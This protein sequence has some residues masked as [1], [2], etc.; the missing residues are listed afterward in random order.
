MRVIA[1]TEASIRSPRIRVRAGRGP[2]GVPSA[3]RRAHLALPAHE[4]DARP[5]GCAARRCRA[6]RFS[7]TRV[8]VRW[9]TKGRSWQRSGRTVGRRRARRFRARAGRA[10][11]TRGPLRCRAVTA[12]RL[13]RDTRAAMADLAV[14]NVLAVLDG[15]PPL[16]P[17]VPV[18]ARCRSQAAGRRP[19]D[20]RCESASW[21]GPVGHHP[22]SPAA[23]RQTQGRRLPSALGSSHVPSGWGVPRPAAAVLTR[24]SL[25][26][27]SPARRGRWRPCTPRCACTR[28]AWS[29]CR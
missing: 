20:E 10:S 13:T 17:V 9:W 12:P 1:H 28:C 29:T 27:S 4:R 6:V 19:T 5:H 8:A 21:L 22:P 24:P 26:A 7:S 18:L 16:T 2:R 14:D 23:V 3:G 15:R 11:W 25:A